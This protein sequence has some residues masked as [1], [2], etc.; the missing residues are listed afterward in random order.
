MVITRILAAIA[1]EGLIALHEGLASRSDID[2]A[3]KLGANHPRGPLDWAELLGLDTVFQTLRT[4]ES[5][6]GDA[7]QPATR[8]RRL[9]QAGSMIVG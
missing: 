8:L 4:L 9:V 3:V 5:E 7:Y 1:N 6:L 2:T